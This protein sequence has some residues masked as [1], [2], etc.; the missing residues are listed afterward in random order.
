AR[1][2]TSLTM[3]VARRF[4]RWYTP[5]RGV[6]PIPPGGPPMDSDRSVSSSVDR[7]SAL[8]RIS[9]SLTVGSFATGPA[10]SAEPPARAPAPLPR[11]TRGRLK[12]GCQKRPTT[13]EGV[14]IWQRFGVTHVCGGPEPKNPDR[15][16]WTVEELSKIRDLCEHAKLTLAMMWEP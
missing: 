3:D 12:L 4:A 5:G 6:V 14:Q 8:G 7:R 9:A 13:A 11:P 10:P 1:E 15:G 16:Y 2:T